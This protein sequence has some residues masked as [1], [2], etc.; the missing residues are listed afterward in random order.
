M[1][2]IFK[3]VKMKNMNEVVLVTYIEKMK[4]DI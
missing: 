4:K 1:N 2:M 3:R